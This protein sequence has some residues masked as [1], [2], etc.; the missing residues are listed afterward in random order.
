MPSDTTMNVNLSRDLYR[1]VRAAVQS[2]RYASASEV[3]RDALRERRDNAL[4]EIQRKIE[5]GLKSAR[6]GNLLDGEAVI[7][8]LRELGQRRRVGRKARSETTL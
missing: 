7:G 3:V 4:R 5:E 6:D 8:E 2:G 1:F